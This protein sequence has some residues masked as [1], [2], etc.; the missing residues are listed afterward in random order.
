MDLSEHRE[1]YDLILSEFM[2]GLREELKP[3]ALQ[4]R[5]R[6]LMEEPGMI[7]AA[8]KEL[9]RRKRFRYRRVRTIN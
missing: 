9:K 5:I 3:K 2:K 4:K 6:A 8:R 7:E 1:I